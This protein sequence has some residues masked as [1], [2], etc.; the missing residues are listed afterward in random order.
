[1]KNKQIIKLLSLFLLVAVISSGLFA[2]FPSP[3]V[4]TTTPLHSTT[5]SSATTRPVGSTSSSTTTRPIGSTSSS[6]TTRPIGSTSSSTT[7]RPSGTTTSTTTGGG[8]VPGGEH[9]DYDNNGYCDDCLIDVVETLDFYN[10]N[11]LHGKLDDSD[12]QPGVDELSAY[13]QGRKEIDEHVIILSTGDMWQGSAESGLTRG[14]IITDWMNYLGFEAMALGNH[15]FDWG[16]TSIVA[17]AEIAEFPFLAINIYDN[18][19]GKRVDYCES[20]I[21]IERGGCQIGLIG[22]IGDCY[23]SISAEMTKGIRF[24]TGTEL[25]NLVKAESEKLRAAGADIIVYML[26]DGTSYSNVPNTSGYYD[27]SLSAGGYVDLVFEGHSH[28]YYV[29]EDSYGVPHLQGGGDN[30]AGISHVEV[31]VNFANGSIEYN[32]SNNIFHSSYSNFEDDPKIDELLEKYWDE[33]KIAYE[34]LGNNKYY[35]NGSEISSTVAK[36]YY[37]AG[38]AKWGDKYDIVLAGGSIDTRKP[39]SVSAGIVKYAELQTILPFDNALYLCEVSG[40]T[41]IKTFINNS[42]YHVYY[43]IDVST[44][45][46]NATYYIIADSWTAFY[47]YAYCTPIE[48]YDDTTFARDLLA[49]YIQEGNWN[50]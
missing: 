29:F 27:Q 49:K 31:D 3:E 36:L 38:V 17:N 24:K 2:C 8:S 48:K 39:N 6:T 5:S 20:S 21:M 19:T 34:D 15:E 23:S 41:L 11:D 35:R 10:F 33:I 12:T 18:A 37:E 50:K 22:A 40:Y 26:H 28:S 32:I 45:D 42:K 13:L 16:P 30:S 25:T 14:A 43:T 9:V 7:T 1:M 44:I 46:R 47:T 4:S